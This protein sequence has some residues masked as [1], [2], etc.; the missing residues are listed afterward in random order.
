MKN[1]KLNSDMHT[2]S[3]VSSLTFISRVHPFG[4][5][6]AAELLLRQFSVLDFHQVWRHAERIVLDISFPLLPATATHTRG[7]KGSNFHW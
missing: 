2:V 6:E 1:K 7:S 5:Q 3:E 4:Q